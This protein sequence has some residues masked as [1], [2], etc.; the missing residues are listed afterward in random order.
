M[1]N[2]LMMGAMGILL[3]TA[4]AATQKPEAKVANKS[5]FGDDCV[6]TCK[7]RGSEPDCFSM[8]TTVYGAPSV[9]R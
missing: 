7:A 5:M 2:K 6:Q 8:C 4:C 9:A 3:A 1:I